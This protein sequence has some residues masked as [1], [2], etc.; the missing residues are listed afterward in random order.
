MKRQYS[1]PTAEK[2]SF[3]YR[4]QILTDSPTNC[5]ESVMNQRAS[6]GISETTPGGTTCVG[7]TPFS[8]GWNLPET[9]VGG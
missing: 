6:D 3:N 1:K 8:F 4:T 5:F 7:G 2:I 9:L